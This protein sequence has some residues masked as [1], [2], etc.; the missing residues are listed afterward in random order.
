MGPSMMGKEIGWPEPH[1]RS[2][3][4]EMAKFGAEWVALV[5]KLLDRGLI[6]HH[7]LHV[8]PG[9]LTKVLGGLEAIRSKKISGKKLVYTM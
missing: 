5:Q 4:P 9:G 3:D 7:P 1:R 2:A 6:R 8:E